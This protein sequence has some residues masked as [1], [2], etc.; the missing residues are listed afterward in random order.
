MIDVM[1][2]ARSLMACS[3]AHTD[4]VSAIDSSVGS[5]TKTVFAPIAERK[6][7]NVYEK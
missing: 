7:G 4:A 3:Q 5:I 2:A 6:V 1:Y